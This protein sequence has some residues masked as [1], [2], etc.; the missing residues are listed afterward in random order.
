VENLI[1]SSL[2][3]GIAVP[4]MFEKR[5]PLPFFLRHVNGFR[6]GRGQISSQVLALLRISSCLHPGAPLAPIY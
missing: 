3:N 1:L 5:A 6:V 2:T 4:F